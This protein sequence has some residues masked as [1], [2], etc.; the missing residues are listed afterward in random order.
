MKSSY[1][2][3]VSSLLEQAFFR[4]TGI[5]AIGAFDD[6]YHDT[7]EK[8]ER[9]YY[10]MLDMAV[11]RRAHT[12]A[13]ARNMAG[14]IDGLASIEGKVT[15]EMPGREKILRKLTAIGLG[16]VVPDEKKK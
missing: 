11:R 16:M 14:A 6:E 8:L 2:D 3:K 9:S 10:V 15:D 1:R 5:R 13:Q 4:I 7:Q 12:R